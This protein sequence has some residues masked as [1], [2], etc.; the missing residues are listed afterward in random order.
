[1]EIVENIPAFFDPDGTGVLQVAAVRRQ[2]GDFDPQ[3]EL[4]RYLGKND[5]QADPA[6][7]ARFVLPGGIPAVSV[8][9]IVDN[10]FWMVVAAAE[11]PRFVLLMYNGDEVPSAETALLIS[12]IISTLEF[13]AQ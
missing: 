4:E 3:S 13:S 8:E 9:Y 1:M 10:R 6:R 7:M 5:I 12:E 11:G 2:S